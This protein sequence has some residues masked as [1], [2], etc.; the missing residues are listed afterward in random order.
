MDVNNTPQYDN[1]SKKS[2]DLHHD[3]QLKKPNGSPLLQ[4]AS[5]SNPASVAGAIAGMIREKGSCELQ[6]IGAGA[7]NQSVKSIAIARGYMA[8]SGIELVCIPAFVDVKINNEDRTAIKFLIQQRV[9][10]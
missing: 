7:V 2:D 8:P 9:Y 4:V 6:A 3:E 10:K 1:Q 5:A